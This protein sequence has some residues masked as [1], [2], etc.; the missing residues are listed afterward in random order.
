MHFHKQGVSAHLDRAATS[1]AIQSLPAHL[2]HSP[3]GSAVSRAECLGE[4]YVPGAR[5]NRAGV[6]LCRSCASPLRSGGSPGP[7]HNAPSFAQPIPSGASGFSSLP[8][9]LA[10]CC[11]P[12]SLAQSAP[13]FWLRPRLG[14]NPALGCQLSTGSGDPAQ[15]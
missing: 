2:G 3:L 4:V 14:I 15:L 11:L 9:S 1:P 7:L 8:S 10:L 6:R 5:I 13:S 12:S